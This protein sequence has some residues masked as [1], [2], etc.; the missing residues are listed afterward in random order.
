MFEEKAELNSENSEKEDFI[1][2]NLKFLVLLIL[3]FSLFVRIYWSTQKQGLH[4]DEVLSITLANRSGINVVE[5]RIYHKNDLL[6]KIF[7]NNASVKDAANDVV[8]LYQNSKDAP[9]TNFYYT[10]LRLS[11]FGRSTLDLKNIIYT[12]IALNCLIFSVGFFFFYKLLRLLFED[13]LIILIGLF[14]V[15]VAGSAISNAMFLRPYQL[16]SAMLIILTYVIAKILIAKKFTRKTFIILSLAVA[17]ALLSGY[18]STIYIGLFALFV[19]GYYFLNKEFKRVFFYAASFLAGAILAQVFYLRYWQAIFGGTDRAGEAYQKVNLGYFLGNMLS[20]AQTVYNLLLNYAIYYLPIILFVIVLNVLFVVVVKKHKIK[21]NYLALGI[22]T[23][24]L[25]FSL[26]VIEL[27]PLKVIRYI[28]P[29]FPLISLIIPLGINSFENKFIKNGI[30]VLF[31]VIFAVNC[32]NIAKINYLFGNKLNE[33]NFLEGDSSAV[34]FLGSAGWRFLDW[35]PYA[36]NNQSYLFFYDAK[37]LSEYLKKA[38]GA[39][40]KCDY[41]VLDTLFNKQGL[42]DVHSQINEKFVIL[43]S[44]SSLSDDI[45]GSEMLKL[46]LKN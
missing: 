21:I 15:S 26:I 30:M 37:N 8:S 35:I 5:N 31:V 42:N 25:L 45:P 4:M 17:G 39:D 2:K 22:V 41:V 23:V 33:N 12:G 1:T 20:S 9:H 29:V 46:Q 40:L 19:S 14:C 3:F 7:I 28:M 27:A 16:Q 36:K 32:F 43:S 10:L 11:F 18:F 13:K 44:M 34:C 38:N 6:K 24:S